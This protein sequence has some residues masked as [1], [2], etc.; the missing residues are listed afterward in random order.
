[1]GMWTTILLVVVLAHFVFGFGYLM[2]K[3]SPKRRDKDEEI[4]DN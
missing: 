3:L 2:V 1:M 4:E